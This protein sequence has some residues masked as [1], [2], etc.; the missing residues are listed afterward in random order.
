MLWA[1]VQMGY[2]DRYFL[3]FEN[4]DKSLYSN[5]DCQ[6]RYSRIIQLM[7]INIGISIDGSIL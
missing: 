5:N 2:L 3:D 6:R 7:I 1:S 4:N